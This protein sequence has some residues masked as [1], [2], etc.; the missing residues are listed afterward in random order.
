MCF[1][2]EVEAVLRKEREVCDFSFGCFLGW[3]HSI[4]QDG[5]TDHSEIIVGIVV[6][7]VCLEQCILFG[8][9][10]KKF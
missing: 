1:L 10:N 6:T 7:A 2:A 4:D 9:E 8:N 5:V 3:Y